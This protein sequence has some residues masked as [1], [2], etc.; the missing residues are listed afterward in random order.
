MMTK[1]R[2]AFDTVLAR[3]DQLYVR[4]GAL[5]DERLRQA[6]AGGSTL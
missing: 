6:G 5:R 4:A 3:A 2:G 1:D